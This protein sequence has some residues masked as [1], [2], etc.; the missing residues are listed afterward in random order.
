MFLYFPKRFSSHLVWGCALNV[1]MSVYFWFLLVLLYVTVK[2]SLSLKRGFIQNLCITCDIDLFRLERFYVYDVHLMQHA[3]RNNLPYVT[4]S[5]QTEKIT[6]TITKKVT[7][8]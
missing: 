7:A 5:E 6:A 1:I 8:D 4:I 2:S 3:K